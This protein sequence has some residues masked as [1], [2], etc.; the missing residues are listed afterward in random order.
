VGGRRDP[1]W[2]LAVLGASGM[3][4][5]A[6]AEAKSGK[7]GKEKDVVRLERDAVISIMKP[8]LIMKLAFLIGISISH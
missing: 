8:K 7:A 3:Q 5:P 6:M 2:R 4:E 1:G